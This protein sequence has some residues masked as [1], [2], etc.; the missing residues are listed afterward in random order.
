MSPEERTRIRF[1]V[2]VIL[3][4]GVAFIARLYY[5][6][7]M[8][9]EEFRARALSQYVSLRPDLYDRGSIFFAEKDGK[10]VAAATISSG[11]TIAIVPKEIVDPEELFATLTHEVVIDR[12][13]FMQ[14]A[15][16]HDDPYEVILE[17]VGETEAKRLLEKELP[18][19]S[20]SL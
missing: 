19:S 9:G 10:R 5:L 18:A 6:Q 4:F 13:D 8:H 1:L 12:D 20:L 16:L 15:A 14:K 11:Y 7:I 2:A 17:R 3:C